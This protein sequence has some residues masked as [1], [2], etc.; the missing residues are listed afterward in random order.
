MFKPGNIAIVSVFFL[1][2]ETLSPVKT[3]GLGS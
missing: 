3:V 2:I 1:P